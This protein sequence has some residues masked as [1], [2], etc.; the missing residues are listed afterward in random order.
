MGNEGTVKGAAAREGADARGNAV[1]IR[2][3]GP[4]TLRYSSMDSQSRKS[5]PR[6]VSNPVAAAND[7]NT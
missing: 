4:Q 6:W 7:L 2:C 1:G 5:R 3:N